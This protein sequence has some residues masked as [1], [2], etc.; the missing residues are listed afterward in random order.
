M[1]DI[2]ST[3]KKRRDI[4]NKLQISNFAEAKSHLKNRLE[5]AITQELLRAERC[6]E[7]D[8]QV[9]FALP[10]KNQNKKCF[11]SCNKQAMLST[12]KIINKIEDG[13]T[14]PVL[15]L[16]LD[17]INFVN[18]TL[19]TNYPERYNDFKAI[20]AII[21]VLENDDA[22]DNEKIKI[23]IPFNSN[24]PVLNISAC[25]KVT[26][27]QTETLRPDL[28]ETNTKLR[29]KKNRRRRKS[30]LSKNLDTTNVSEN[31]TKIIARFN[32]SVKRTKSDELLDQLEFFIVENLNNIL[33]DDE[34]NNYLRQKQI[35]DNVHLPNF[36]CSPNSMNFLNFRMICLFYT[37][38]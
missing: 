1:Q 11:K 33:N 5:I 8:V 31:E 29:K 7:N 3:A 32:D 28:I 27:T 21:N 15:P 14:D 17:Y 22:I 23:D 13:T 18:N 12:K 10:E 2:L 20:E 36:R 25:Q 38:N 24:L 16:N 34:D 19:Q 4:E 30:K 37:I 6:S 26:Q 35:H 9:S